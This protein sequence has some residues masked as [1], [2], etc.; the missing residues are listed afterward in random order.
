MC[1]AVAP[2]HQRQTNLIH[3]QHRILVRLKIKKK[4]ILGRTWINE[5]FHMLLGKPIRATVMEN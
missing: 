4:K 1:E 3:G 2:S 5:D